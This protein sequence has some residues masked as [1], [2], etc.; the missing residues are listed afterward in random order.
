M[1]PLFITIWLHKKIFL[2][3]QKFKTLP[4][5]WLKAEQIK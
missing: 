5:S 2:K 1:A 4:I 3:E